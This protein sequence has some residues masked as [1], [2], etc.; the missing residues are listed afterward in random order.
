MFIKISK[1][2]SQENLLNE[3]HVHTKKVKTIFKYRHW[4]HM[5]RYNILLLLQTIFLPIYKLY[6]YSSFS[7]N[8]QQAAAPGVI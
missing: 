8:A 5:M 6:Y 4:R 2:V 7:V 1:R 3:A